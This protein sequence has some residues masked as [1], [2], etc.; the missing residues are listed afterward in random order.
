MVALSSFLRRNPFALY[1]VM[2][3]VAPVFRVPRREIWALFD[4]ENVKRGLHDLETFSSRAAPP[5]GAP[6]DWLI[7]LDPPAHTKLRAL[8]MRTFTPRAVASLEPRI[9]TLTHELIDRRVAGGSLD[10]IHDLAAPLPLLVIGELL[11]VPASDRTRMTRWADAILHLGDTIAGGERAARAAATYRAAREEMQPYVLRHVTERRVAPRDD[12]LSRL[13]HASVDGERLTEEE[14][15][16]FFQLLLLAGSETTT[17]LIANAMLCFLD[18]PE[19]L[20]LLRSNPA[21][22]PSAIEEVLRFRSPLQMV[23]RSTTRDVELG[24]RRIPARKLVL[25]MV[26]SANRDPRQFQDAARFD[27]GRSPNPHVAFGHGIH[28]CIGAALARL[29]AKVALTVLLDRMRE[30]RLA[31][32]W[33]PNTALNV[34][35]PSSLPI[36]F[37]PIG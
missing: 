28:F 36:R 11:G 17:N 33:V 37:T 27:I 20:A 25:L 3:K 19:Q 6:L 14:I 21:L 32:P 31:G 1:D 13:A 8:V 26:G 30:V 34:H 22:L 2:R 23:F 12:L 7:F 10:L 15:F 35:G 16:D 9:E 18:H 5:G 24:R 29:E 4:F